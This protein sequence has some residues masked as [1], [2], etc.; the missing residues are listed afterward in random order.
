GK[1]L[2]WH[3]AKINN[4]KEDLIMRIAVPAK[5]KDL[6]SK[7]ESVFGRT[8]F[9]IVVDVETKEFDVVENE[10]VSAS[11]GAGIT[12]AQCVA[13]SGA[14]AV[15]TFQCGKNAADVLGAANI[16]IF[17]AED[18]TVEEIIDKY[19]KGELKELQEVHSGF[20]KHGGR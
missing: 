18:V 1:C 10:G 9:F 20:H 12:A 17:K 11:G 8:Q 3:E 4:E 6:K 15:V 5:D 19:N 14:D 2:R 7:V 13:D 16:K